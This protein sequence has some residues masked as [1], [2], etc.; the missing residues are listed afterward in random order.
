MTER[1]DRLSEVL[2]GYGNFLREKELAL[3][4]HQP[5]LV[6][7]V[8]EFLLFALLPPLPQLQPMLP[9]HARQAIKWL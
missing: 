7:W 8:R 6:R 3:A 5:Y 9:H 2:D 4:K 1:D